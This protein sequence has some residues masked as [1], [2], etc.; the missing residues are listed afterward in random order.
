MRVRAKMLVVAVLHVFIW[1]S[2]AIRSDAA[3]NE[4]WWSLKPVDRPQIPHLRSANGE[5][6][7]IDQFLLAK[8]EANGL[9]FSPEADR[10]TLI[11]RLSFDL[12][13]LPPKPAEVQAFLKD[14]DPKAYAK[15][16]DQLLASPQYG[17]RWARHWLDVVHY[18]D[19]HGYDKDQPRPNAWRYRD[20][21]IRAFNEDKPYA[22]FVSEQL[23]G[24]VLGESGEAIA[25]MSAS[26]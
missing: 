5:A 4:L 9:S 20:Y 12:I 21:V 6:N 17:E 14:T 13:G 8:L 3:T 11:R 2:S 26:A 18:G 22:Q 19:S 1:F 23:A 24:D 25:A 16:V 7:P 10:R 15:L